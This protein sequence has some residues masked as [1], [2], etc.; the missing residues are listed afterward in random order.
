M[1]VDDVK[2][3]VG[4]QSSASLSQSQNRGIEWRRCLSEGHGPAAFELCRSNRVSRCEENN[5]M[6]QLHKLFGQIADDAF[7]ASI[8]LR[9]YFLP[10]RGD[11]SYPHSELLQIGS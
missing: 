7:S 5:F 6:S 10:Q 8:L 1:I 11:L 2:T 4:L 3:S 9:W